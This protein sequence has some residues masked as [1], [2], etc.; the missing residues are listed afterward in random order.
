M[1]Y[2]LP[3]VE[4]TGLEI[5]PRGRVIS[6]PVRYGTVVKAALLQS[7]A[8]SAAR[9]TAVVLEVC[10]SRWKKHAAKIQAIRGCPA[11]INCYSYSRC[12]LFLEKIKNKTED[13]QASR[14][15]TTDKKN[16]APSHE[17]TNKIK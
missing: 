1:F 6:S 9:M 3:V 15:T 8:T 17:D 14:Q 13:D 12:D 5:G 16:T 4:K 2:T 11:K 7:H 10:T